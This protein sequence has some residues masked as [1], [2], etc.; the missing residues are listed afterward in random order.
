MAEAE[1]KLFAT[2]AV[3]RSP[4]RVQ[5]ASLNDSTAEVSR[6]ASCMYFAGMRSRRDRKIALSSTLAAGQANRGR[7]DDQ[8]KRL[9][10]LRAPEF[11]LAP[12]F[13]EF[14]AQDAR[15]ERSCAAP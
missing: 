9:R 6:R 3:G 12:S 5:I 1:L 7:L 14:D 4:A 13:L 10:R 2:V 11:K 8:A 15:P